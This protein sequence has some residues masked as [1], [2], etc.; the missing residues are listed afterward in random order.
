M[1]GK[2]SRQLFV[3]VVVD[4]VD[5]VLGQI[6]VIRQCLDV[7]GMGFQREH[8]QPQR[9]DG[10]LCMVSVLMGARRIQRPAHSH[11]IT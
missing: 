4:D 3:A 10:A 7:F 9:G 2:S 11:L 1:V 8:Q 6:A 5:Q